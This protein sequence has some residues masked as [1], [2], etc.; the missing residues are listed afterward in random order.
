[1]LL[2][3]PGL[4]LG[5]FIRELLQDQLQQMFAVQSPFHILMTR[6][7]F[8]SRIISAYGRESLVGMHHLPLDY[9]EDWRG[10]HGSN[11]VSA[12]SPVDA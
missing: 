2:A 6:L 12:Q 4:F 10:Y 7:I 8:L 11:M 9:L 3:Y 1:M 5:L